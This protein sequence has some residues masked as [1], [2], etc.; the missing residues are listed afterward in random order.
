MVGFGVFFQQPAAAIAP[1]R[2]EAGG[3]GHLCPWHKLP[4]RRHWGG[5]RT[6]SKGI[7]QPQNGGSAEPASRQGKIKAEKMKK[8]KRKKKREREGSPLSQGG[9]AA[10]AGHAAGSGCGMQD[11][12]CT[13]NPWGGGVSCPGLQEGNKRKSI[14]NKSNWAKGWGSQ[15]WDTVPCPSGTAMPWTCLSPRRKISTSPH[16]SPPIF[17]LDWVSF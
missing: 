6:P 17:S 12:G 2:E 11:S 9:N 10:P 5:T 7:Q 8:K 15:R 14:P 1:A 3:D 13:R 16:R 4:C